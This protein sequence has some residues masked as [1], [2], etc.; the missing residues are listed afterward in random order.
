MAKVGTEMARMRM[1]LVATIAVAALTAAGCTGR[2]DDAT[3]TI[4]QTAEE[5]IRTTVGS[6]SGLGELSPVCPEVPAPVVGSTWQCSATT[7]D[8]RTVT[9]DGVINQDGRVE[10]ATSNVI[11]AAALPSFERAAVKALNETVGSRLSDDD[12]DCGEAP[13]LFAGPERIMVCA[14]FDPHTEETYDVSLTVTNIED[15]QFNLVVADTPRP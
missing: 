7:A 11:A 13:V 10:L 14:L 12:I 5:L 1:I 9:L 6:E 2:S 15:R 4:R 8:Q 3:P